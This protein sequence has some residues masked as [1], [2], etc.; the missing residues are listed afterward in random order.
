MFSN[1]YRDRLSA[2]DMLHVRKVIEHVYEKV[3]G[4]ENASNS[5]NHADKEHAGPPTEEELE[6]LLAL[7]EARVELLCHEQV[8][9]VLINE[10]TPCCQFVSIILLV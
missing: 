10:M 6:E 9:F 2:S 4:N 3:V 8:S 7:A 1:V 5:G